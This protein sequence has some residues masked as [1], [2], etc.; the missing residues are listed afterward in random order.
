MQKSFAW[1]HRR[2][3]PH[4]LRRDVAQEVEQNRPIMRPLSET[5]GLAFVIEFSVESDRA[6]KPDQCHH[7]ENG[8]V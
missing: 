3:E 1:F 8:G 4:C 7:H 6:R 5:H 2:C